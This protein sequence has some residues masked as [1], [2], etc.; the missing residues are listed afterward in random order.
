LFLSFGTIFLS[1]LG[2]KSQLATLSISGSSTAPKFVFIG[3]ALA[4]LMA[5]AIG[6]FLGDS[7]SIFLPTKI[8]KAIAAALFAI[9]AM[10]LLSPEANES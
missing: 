3:S 8:L 7:I 1:E 5:S 4:L 9:M 10:R 2:D 6:V